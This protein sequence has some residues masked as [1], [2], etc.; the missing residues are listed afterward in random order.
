MNTE[1]YGNQG[2][3]TTVTT[4]AGDGVNYYRV[5]PSPCPSCGRCPT[6]GKGGWGYGY[7]PYN[8]TPIWC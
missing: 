7:P 1:E 6:C 5:Y 3:V 2:S 4:T 8:P